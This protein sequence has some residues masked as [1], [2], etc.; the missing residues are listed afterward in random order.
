MIKKNLP[1]LLS[2][3]FCVS[4]D[5]QTIYNEILSIPE[6]AWHSTMPAYFDVEVSDT[7]TYNTIYLQISNTVSYKYQ[8]IYLFVTVF[9]PN[10]QVARDTVNCDLANNYGEWY[11][12]GIGS[13]KTLHLPYRT[14]F[15]FPYTG[16]YK[17]YI[18]QAMRDDTL[19]GIKAIGLKISKEQG[20]Q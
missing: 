18:E 15:L 11:G 3:F 6:G 7:L 5:T 13:T 1:L 16:L 8:N 10:G 4:C 20:L 2:L 19:K 9:L 14:N 17:F 12:K